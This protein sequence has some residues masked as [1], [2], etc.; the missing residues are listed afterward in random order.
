MAGVNAQEIKKII[1]AIEANGI[2]LST[3]NF[4]MTFYPKFLENEVERISL[5]PVSRISTTA[6][7]GA[8]KVRDDGIVIFFRKL[9]TTSQ[10]LT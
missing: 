6:Q 7:V 10:K 5:M 2:D 3:V 4:E 1:E 9:I 8:Y